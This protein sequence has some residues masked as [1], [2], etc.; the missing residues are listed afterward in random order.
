MLIFV[1]KY[2]LSWH[3]VPLHGLMTAKCTAMHRPYVMF[4]FAAFLTIKICVVSK[5]LLSQLLISNFSAAYPISDL[6]KQCLQENA[7][8]CLRYSPN[9]TWLVTSRLDT[10]QH[11]TFDVSSPCILAVSSLSNSSA[12]HARLDALDMTKVSCRVETW[13]D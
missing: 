3:N 13:H 5:S 11:D 6:F 1:S 12:R 4:C 7:S 8:S 10:T 9:S 2:I